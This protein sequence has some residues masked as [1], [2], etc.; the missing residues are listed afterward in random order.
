M[1]YKYH[2]IAL[3]IVIFLICIIY[4]P[5]G[6]Q[7]CD[8]DDS[9]VADSSNGSN[10]ES[11]TEDKEQ[12]DPMDM[13]SPD[14]IKLMATSCASQLAE[15]TYTHV[16]YPCSQISNMKDISAC[17]A[18]YT[19]YYD[20]IL[21]NPVIDFYTNLKNLEGGIYFDY[22]TTINSKEE[23]A[24]VVEMSNAYS[25]ALSLTIR[26]ISSNYGIDGFN[27][28]TFIQVL[29]EYLVECL[30]D[31][32]VNLY[33]NDKTQIEP[34]NEP[35]RPSTKPSADEMIHY[36]ENHDEAIQEARQHLSVEGEMIHQ[37]I[38]EEIRQEIISNLESENLDERI[39]NEIM[40]EE[41]EENAEGSEDETKIE[42]PYKRLG[43][44]LYLDCNDIK[45]NR[46]RVYIDGMKLSCRND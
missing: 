41:E 25:R 18:G 19:R 16:V 24:F 33:T 42:K 30:S 43:E 45:N 9:T 44:I 40:D 29:K 39:H 11:E 4:P 7:E 27:N 10:D 34:D 35:V 36:V 2:L 21:K 12:F 14:N 3:I 23:Y 38:M 8:S 37:N 26:F 22:S 28:Q 6:S 1:E 32:V 15:E 20:R 13:P 31:S 5:S 17:I 46:V